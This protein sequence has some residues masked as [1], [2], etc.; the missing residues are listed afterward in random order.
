MTITDRPT[1]G[2]VPTTGASMATAATNS[3]TNSATSSAATSPLSTAALSGIGL[4]SATI[5][6]HTSELSGKVEETAYLGFGYVLLIA[7]SI[8]SIVLL[9][10]RDR[11]GW[12]LGGATCA[13]TLVGFVLTRTTGLPGANGDIGNWGE[14]IAIWSLI[15]EGAFVAL[16]A[17]AF[18]AE[19]RLTAR[20]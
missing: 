20:R 14:T 13:A 8:I 2:N 5:A 7:A 19:S 15:V 1:T 6:I 12:L 17:W 18:Q 11:R 4:L 16:A 10:Q 3:T 9:A